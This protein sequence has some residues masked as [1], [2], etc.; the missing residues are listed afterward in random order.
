MTRAELEKEFERLSAKYDKALRAAYESENHFY[1]NRPKSP[2]LEAKR[3]KAYH[4]FD[5]IRNQLNAIEQEEWDKKRSK[6]R[7]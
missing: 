1:A 5:V 3:M 4:E 2:E 6:G 7:S